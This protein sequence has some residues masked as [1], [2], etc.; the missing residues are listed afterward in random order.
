MRRAVERRRV[1]AEERARDMVLVCGKLAVD[2]DSVVKMPRG[3]NG[4]GRR[5]SVNDVI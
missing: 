1:W 4:L 2:V 5:L 3:G